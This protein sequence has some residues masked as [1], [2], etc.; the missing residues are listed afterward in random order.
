MNYKQLYFPH[1]L[2]PAKDTVGLKT[3]YTRTLDLPASIIA[4][5]HY[6]L[7]LQ[8][9]AELN[10][11]LEHLVEQKTEELAEVVASNTK[12]IAIIAHDLR[13]PFTSIL[14]VLELL[15]MNL[16]DYNITKIEQ[17]INIAADSANN[18]LAL[19]ESLLSWT[20]SQ[21]KEKSFNPV[22]INLYE[23]LQDEIACFKIP[24]TQKQLTLHHSIK[25]DIN[26]SA[27]LQMVKTIFRN[28][29]SNAIKYTNVGDI[30]ISALEHKQIVEIVVKDNGV[31]MLPEVQSKLFKNEKLSSTLGTNNVQGAGLGL[32][33]CKEFVE[34]HGGIIQFESEP[35]I[36]SEF[37]FTLPHYIEDDRKRLLLF[38]LWPLIS[39]F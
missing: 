3:G 20:I 2:I 29:I 26:V 15:K 27:D 35:G 21:N 4:E 16:N 31:G 11:H 13:G 39:V 34:M 32:L 14:G 1:K 36:G 24:A 6:I 9:M 10:I 30:T 19:L 18:T 12:F 23:L 17:F 22:K 8:E 5:K 25:P 28:L 7:R 38:D 37:K 33:I